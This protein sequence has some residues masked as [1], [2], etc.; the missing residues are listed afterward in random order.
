MS[1]VHIIAILYPKPEK[2]SRFQELMQPMIRA[3]HDSEPYTLR[4]IMTK[5]IDG[6][7]PAIHMIETYKSKEGA[8]AHTHTEHFKSLFVKFDKEDIF[9]KPPY[10]AFTKS[11]GGF[12]LGRELI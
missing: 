11:M 8:E 3:V 4:Y 7:V 12:D 10:L 2:S 9:A 6:E 5:Q 1:E